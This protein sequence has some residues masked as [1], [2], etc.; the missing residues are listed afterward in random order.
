M[1]RDSSPVTF[2]L[3]FSPDTK[4]N[5]MISVRCNSEVEGRLLLARGHA[6]HFCSP[7]TTMPATEGGGCLG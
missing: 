3:T 6:H 7:A 5:N 1:I 4:V 2:S